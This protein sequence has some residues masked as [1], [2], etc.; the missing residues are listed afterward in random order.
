M[1]VQSGSQEYFVEAHIGAAGAD[2]IQGNGVLA[3]GGDND[4]LTGGSQIDF[5]HGGSGSDILVGGLAGDLLYGDLGIDVASYE[6]AGGSITVSLADPAR[7]TGEAAGDVYSSIEGLTGSAYNDRLVGDAL[8]NVLQGG[9]GHDLLEGGEGGDRLVGG[10]GIDFADYENATSGVTAKLLMAQYNAG[11]AAGDVYASI[12][13]IIGSRFGDELAG[14]N[15][16]NDLQGRDGNDRLIG[17]GGNDRLEGGAGDDTLYGGIGADH[18]I[19]GAGLDTVAYTVDGVGVTVH[20]AQPHLNTGE[21][22]GDTY[23]GIENV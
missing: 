22:A 15:G 23:D 3:G 10:D 7:N 17:L 19:G 8:H 6:Q 1:E 4:V 2:F 9:A 11:E 13:G 16:T 12:E 21:A 18:L 5:L 14:D 20:L